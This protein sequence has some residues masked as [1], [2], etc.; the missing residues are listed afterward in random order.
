[1][2]EVD[3]VDR[4]DHVGGGQREKRQQLVKELG[5][6]ERLQRVV[7]RRVPAVDTANVDRAEKI[8]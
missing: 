5:S 2:A 4:A 3:L 8:W 7:E 1:M 6:V